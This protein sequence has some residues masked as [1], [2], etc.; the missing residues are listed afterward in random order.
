MHPAFGV[1][2]AVLA[3]LGGHSLK[4][5]GEAGAVGNSAAK[6]CYNDRVTSTT[7]A[8]HVRVNAHI[9]WVALR[10]A[11]GAVVERA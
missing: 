2:A 3:L 1:G 5:Q 8:T 6:G 10:P 7:D 9:F 11:T 4:W